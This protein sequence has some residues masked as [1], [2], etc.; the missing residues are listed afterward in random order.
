MI[1]ITTVP[2]YALDRTLQLWR[3]PLTVAQT[4]LHQDRDAMTW[5]PVIAF[6]RFEAG[7]RERVGS[8]LHDE[9]LLGRARLQRTKLAQLEKAVALEAEAAQKDMEAEAARRDR[10][11][12][13]EE[14]REAAQ[15]QADEREQALERDREKAQA[16]VRRQAEER[17]HAEARLAEQRREAT[18]VREVGAKQKQL[19]AEARALAKEDRAVQAKGRALNLE[20]EAERKKAVRKAARKNGV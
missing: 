17:E 2:G 6:E 8:V 15:R 12:T 7:A 19:D 1:D 20:D 16:A 9:R 5:P 10:Q 13:A 4:A 11:Q 3:L 18:Q 14:R